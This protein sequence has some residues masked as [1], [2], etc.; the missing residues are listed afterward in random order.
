MC[1]TNVKLAL[2]KGLVILI[3][4]WIVL[5]D[6]SAASRE[7]NQQTLR[8]ADLVVDLMMQSEE[9]Q[10][11]FA[12]IA[13]DELSAAYQA[14]LDQVRVAV[15]K[16]QKGQQKRRRWF[17]AT[18]IFLANL[19]RASQLLNSY[20]SFRLYIDKKHNVLIV[21]D[22][23]PIV[24]S[25]PRIN[26]EVALEKRIIDRY[27]SQKECLRPVR[28]S[29][30]DNFEQQFS[31]PGSWLLGQSGRIEYVTGDGLLFEFN[32]MTNRVEKR[33]AVHAVIIELRHIVISLKR[34]LH[35]GGSIDWTGIAIISSPADNDH[36]F[37]LNNQGDYIRIR[38]PNLHKEGNILFEALPWLHARVKGEPYQ[39]KISNADRLLSTSKNQ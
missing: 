22:D 19:Q 2:L 27:C 16:S 21:V 34:Y 37:V 24:V 6:E 18:N 5:A 4:L 11:M 15:A 14:E 10:R 30:Y 20:A 28:N 39:L 35:N 29:R 23:Q 26:D 36:K 25:G 12:H 1:F 3:V 7:I 32:N 17:I 38:L 13:L 33:E 31:A 9:E 8:L